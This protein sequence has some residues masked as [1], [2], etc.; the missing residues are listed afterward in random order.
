MA[1]LYKH[2]EIGQIERATCKI[3]YCADGQVLRNQGDGWKTWKKLKPGV[4]P[5]EHFDKAKANYANKLATMPAFAEWRRLLHSIVSFSHRYMVST[6]ISTMP[7]DPDGVWSECNDMLNISM[8]VEEAVALCR[9]YEAAEQEAKE[10][11]AQGVI[12]APAV[13]GNLCQPLTA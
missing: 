3:A 13:S 11:K 4:N 2:G 1:T 10:I 7:Q 8:D 6:V 5:Q 9:A 12:H